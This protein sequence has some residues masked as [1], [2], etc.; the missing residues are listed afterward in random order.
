MS[1]V[2]LMYHI[3]FSTK[4]RRPMIAPDIMARLCPYLGGIARKGYGQILLAGGTE[5]H[6]H[7]AAIV[8]P[9]MALADFVRDIKCN[10]SLWVHEEFPS[11]AAFTWQ[12]GYGGFT[13]SSSMAPQVEEYIAAQK[14]HHQRQDFRTEFL[15]L[16]RRHGIEHDENDVF[17]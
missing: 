4:E 6:V 12:E 11:A 17:R 3:V 10:S 8:H 9:S 13:V 1:Y 5:N 15:E 7:V 16:L 2:S 14:R